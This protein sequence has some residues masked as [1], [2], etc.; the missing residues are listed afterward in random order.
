MTQE[1][2]WCVFIPNFHDHLKGTIII[3]SL[4]WIA[5]KKIFY[6]WSLSS[7]SQLQVKPGTLW[8]DGKNRCS[9]GIIN[10]QIPLS[11]HSV[12]QPAGI[13]LKV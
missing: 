4:K 9:N 13:K 7:G 5:L 12:D 2:R 3:P 6:S 11:N 8:A 10:N 1:F